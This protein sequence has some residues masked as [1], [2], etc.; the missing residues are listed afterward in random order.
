MRFI[1]PECGA[2]A[3]FPQLFVKEGS[4]EL[5]PGILERGIGE[6]GDEDGPPVLVGKVQTLRHLTAAHRHEARAPPLLHCRVVIWHSRMA[7]G[8]KILRKGT[9]QKNIKK[10]H[11][12]EEY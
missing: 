2:P 10:R 4:L 11:V 5:D 9:R 7:R 6:P 1:I 3:P 12:A 8:R